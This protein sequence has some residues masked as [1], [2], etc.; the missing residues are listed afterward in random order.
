MNKLWVQKQNILPEGMPQKFVYQKKV[1]KDSIDLLNEEFKP[2]KNKEKFNNIKFNEFQRSSSSKISD[3][4]SPYT[5]TMLLKIGKHIKRMKQSIADI[6][7][8]NALCL[9][10]KVK[11]V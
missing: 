4:V 9:E 5:K 6:T 8:M 3:E 1:M 7:K 11:K 2:N 10:E